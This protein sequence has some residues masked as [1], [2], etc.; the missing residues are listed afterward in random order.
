MTT[1][2]TDSSGKAL[3]SILIEDRVETFDRSWSQNKEL[4]LALRTTPDV[5]NDHKQKMD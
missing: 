1:Y 5:Q 2:H 3:A 4:Y